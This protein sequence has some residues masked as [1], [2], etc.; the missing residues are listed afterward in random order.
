MIINVLK[1]SEIFSILKDDEL[2]EISKLFEEVKLKD[3]SY[4]FMEGDPCKWLYLVAKG[5]VKI[6]KNTASGKDVILEIKSP[7][8]IFGCVAVLDNKP[9][10]A[11]AQAMESTSIIR[12]SRHNLLKVLEAYPI[13]KLNIARYFSDRLK[14]AHELL[15]NIAT[16]RVEKRIASMLLKLSEKVGVDANGLKKIDFP[17]TRQEIAEMVGTTVETCIRTM[18]KFQKNGMVKTSRNRILINT[19]SLRNFLEH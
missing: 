10:P 9:Y 7:G 12:M 17:L 3:N 8:D 1:K 13:L 19:D 18:S 16:E 15:K 14:D 6:F 5:R 4:A 2:K 11:S